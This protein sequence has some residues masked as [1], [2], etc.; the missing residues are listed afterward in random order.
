MVWCALL[1]AKGCVL[2]TAKCFAVRLVLARGGL[3]STDNG[4]RRF[5]SHLESGFALCP[6]EHA[7]ARELLAAQTRYWLF[8][9]HQRHA[10]G[11]FI[12]VDRS[13][14]EARCRWFAIE[15]KNAAR[16][17]LGR[18]GIQL[19]HHHQAVDWLAVHHGLL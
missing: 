13:G 11:D 15:L 7:F 3:F 6:A 1:S 5:A 17:R 19:A 12:A 8:R 10:S 4:R 2:A 16:L 9:T 14:G 18:P